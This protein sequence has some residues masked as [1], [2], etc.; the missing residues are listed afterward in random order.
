M[1]IRNPKLWDQRGYVHETPDGMKY[2]L[3][4]LIVAVSGRARKVGN[5]WHACDAND[6]LSTFH[7]EARDL[8]KF[9]SSEADA[10]FNGFV[11]FESTPEK[12]KQLVYERL[13][14]K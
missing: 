3:A 1:F 12:F 6:A 9:A 13:G 10:I 2:C 14:I 8:L 4:G 11:H 5:V 7:D